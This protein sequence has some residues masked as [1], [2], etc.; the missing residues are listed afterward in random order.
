MRRRGFADGWIQ[1]VKF[2]D[3]GT[4]DGRMRRCGIAAEGKHRGRM[5][6]S[7]DPTFWAGISVPSRRGRCATF[8]LAVRRISAKPSA[9]GSPLRSRNASPIKGGGECCGPRCRSGST[10]PGECR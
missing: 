6:V 3:T 4:R 1:I 9:A 8:V 10:V 7:S 5:A 2:S